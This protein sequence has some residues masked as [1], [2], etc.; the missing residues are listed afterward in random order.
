[1][2]RDGG[3]PAHPGAADF[4]HWLSH[5]AVNPRQAGDSLPS[6][7]G[8]FDP[9]TLA[10]VVIAGCTH[11]FPNFMKS[12]FAPVFHRLSLPAPLYS[13]RSQRPPARLLRE[14]ALR[15]NQVEWNRNI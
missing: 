13:S 12:L 8:P 11:S 10:L 3:Q 4:V 6:S 5:R 15:F 1:S 2:R 14:R 7:Y 9:A